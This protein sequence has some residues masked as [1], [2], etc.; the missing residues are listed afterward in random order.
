MTQ[1]RRD[2]I[3][4]AAF[5]LLYPAALARLI[6]VGPAAIVC[7]AMLAI[8]ASVEIVRRADGRNAVGDL[9]SL[10]PTP[11]RRRSR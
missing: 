5:C 7:T 8:V 9:I 4:M 1:D 3:P 10:L 2:R 11:L 6:G